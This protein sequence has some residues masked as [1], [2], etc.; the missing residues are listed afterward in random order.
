MRLKEVTVEI[1]Y[2]LDAGPYKPSSG[3]LAARVVSLPAHGQ[4]VYGS[5]LLG[6]RRIKN[7][8]DAMVGIQT[9]L[10]NY[11]NLVRFTIHP[12]LEEFYTPKIVLNP[13]PKMLS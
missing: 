2:R 4:P 5:D 13:A 12:V 3:I 1:R 8:G 10:A 6:S 11:V 9:G 7:L